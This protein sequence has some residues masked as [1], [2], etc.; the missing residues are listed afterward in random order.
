MNANNGKKPLSLWA[1]LEANKR[2]YDRPV[3]GAEIA[4]T[5][6]EMSINL[7]M[8]ETI[9]HLKAE[10]EARFTGRP[11]ERIN[12]LIDSKD[13]QNHELVQSLIDTTEP[14]KAVERA[15]A[16]FVLYTGTKGVELINKAIEDEAQGSND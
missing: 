2:V 10:V 6:E 1:Q 5:M 11:L 15:R 16:P 7:Q 13:P 9:K 12:Q 8:I 3:S 14:Y 4:K